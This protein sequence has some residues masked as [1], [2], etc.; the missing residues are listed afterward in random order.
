MRTRPSWCSRRREDVTRP[1]LPVVVYHV[2]EPVSW[3]SNPEYHLLLVSDLTSRVQS[4]CIIQSPT[5]ARSNHHP[6]PDK[7]VPVSQQPEERGP[8]QVPRHQVETA[9]HRGTSATR[10]CLLSRCR[11]DSHNAAVRASGTRAKAL[12][13]LCCTDS[14]CLPK[15]S[16]VVLVRLK[17]N[18]L[19]ASW[20]SGTR[21]R[22]VQS[23]RV[24]NCRVC[25]YR[26]YKNFF[27][28]VCVCDG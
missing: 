25:T 5:C 19:I 16:Q 10:S 14:T 11:K 24:A 1:P 2:L 6:V 7:F 28:C 8:R 12:G 26:L 18:L 17:T 3:T 20:K 21:P 23:W 22:A 4:S 13:C 9:Q 27:V 15:Y